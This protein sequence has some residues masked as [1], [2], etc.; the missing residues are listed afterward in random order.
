M[1]NL[2]NIDELLTENIFYYS[3]RKMRKI[4]EDDELHVLVLSLMICLLLTPSRGTLDEQYCSQ[5]LNV[6]QI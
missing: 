5:F 3:E 2:N 1:T 6:I 4:Y